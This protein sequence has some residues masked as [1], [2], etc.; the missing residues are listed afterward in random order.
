MSASA[1][2]A[3]VILAIS[4]APLCVALIRKKVKTDFSIQIYPRPHLSQFPAMSL[5]QEFETAVK[6]RWSMYSDRYVYIFTCGLAMAAIVLPFVAPPILTAGV[7]ALTVFFGQISVILW[8][9]R[10]WMTHFEGKGGGPNPAINGKIYYFQKVYENDSK[11]FRVELAW[12]HYQWLEETNEMFPPESGAKVTLELAK[13]IKADPTLEVELQ[14]AGIT[15]APGPTV[16]HKLINNPTRYDWNCFFN[17]SGKHTINFIFKQKSGKEEY[18]LGTQALDID[19]IRFW[20]LTKRQLFA[21]AILGSI[22]AIIFGRNELLQV[23]LGF[24]GKG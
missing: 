23:V 13:N 11:N 16:S 15:L 24:L 8:K 1:I 7:F 12:Q 22:A 18:V 17:N 9:R 14:A 3:L 20:F 4:L 19:V 5:W 21:I 10:I 6:D 2:T